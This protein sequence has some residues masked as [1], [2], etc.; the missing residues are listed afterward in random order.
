MNIKIRTF[1]FVFLAMTLS[2]SLYA[3]MQRVTLANA[4]QIGDFFN[5]TTM[6]VMDAN[7]FTGFNFA[8]N[9][10]MKKYW[11][12]T[13]WEVI[14]FEQFETMRTDS[15]L[16]FIFMSKVKL[17]TDRSRG[18]DVEYLYMN[19]VMGGNART[20]TAMP[21]LLSI[22]LAYTGV[23]EDAY[24]EKLPLMIRFAQIH[25]NNL[26]NAPNAR[27]LRR[28][29]DLKNYSDAAIELKDMTLLVL[30]SDLAEEVNTLEK[31]QAV[32]PGIVKI[33]SPEELELAIVE[34]SANT[35]I[36]HQI[37]PSED[38]NTG[39]SYCQIYGTNDARLHYFNHYSIRVRRP[40]GMLARD[41]RLILGRWF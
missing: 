10:G 35:A 31:I 38:D 6:L 14:S 29:F 19:I 22:P 36:L 40:E 9:E 33:V 20:L 12:I 28:T 18:R 25:L 24:I 23:D 17:D 8:S 1:F 13:P 41:F 30:Q 5:S 3:Q 15:K 16:S 39:R 34:H 21:E 26:K 4:K 32:Y 37:G 11:T 2:S 27:A 7:P